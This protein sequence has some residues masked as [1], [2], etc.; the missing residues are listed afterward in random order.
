[1]I[2]AKSITKGFDSEVLIC[3][4]KFGGLIRRDSIEFFSSVAMSTFFVDSPTRDFFRDD[5][6]A[7]TA[8]YATL[9]CR[10]MIWSS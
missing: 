2:P 1:L 7:S 9:F 5:S 8:S 3:S 6:I 4:R 10:R